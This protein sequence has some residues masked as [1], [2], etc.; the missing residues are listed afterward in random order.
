MAERLNYTNRQTIE[1]ADVHI[2]LEKKGMHD[3]FAARIDF[4]NYKF[5]SSAR[6][7]IEAYINNHLVRFDFGTVGEFG[8]Q[9]STDL[10]DF[11]DEVESILYRV[12]VVAADEKRTIL[13]LPS[14]GVGIRAENAYG[15]ASDCI[16]PLG[17]LPKESGL[18]WAMDYEKGYP[19]LCI[20][21]E[22]DPSVHKSDA[23]IALVYPTALRSVL[24]YTFLLHHDGQGCNWADDW[25]RFA[26]ENLGEDFPALSGKH[27]YDEEDLEAINDW[28]DDVVE[29]FVAGSDL[30]KKLNG[31]VV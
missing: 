22:L 4:E 30:V 14:R 2:T 9:V 25:K 7:F 21:P 13:G 3:S 1:S 11:G 27:E 12:K 5:P 6:V 18:V 24:E 20:N 19:R 10:S 29:S 23:F 31:G 26:T 17:K 28:I 15:G 16:L 8:P